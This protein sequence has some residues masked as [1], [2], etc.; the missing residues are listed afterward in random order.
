MDS[1][2]QQS[3]PL[4]IELPPLPSSDPD[5]DIEPDWDLGRIAKTYR[6]QVYELLM[7]QQAESQG[8]RSVVEVH[9]T[10]I[11]QLVRY[12]FTAATRLYTRRYTSLSQRCSVF[13][14]GG[15]GRGEL[16][17]HSDIDLLFLYHWKITPYAETVWETLYYSLMDAGWTVGHAV[18]NI[19]EC[20][21]QAGR[22]FEIKTSLL[23]SRYL[24]GEESLAQEFQ[25]AMQ[26]D[27]VEKRAEQFFQAKAEESRVR[28]QRHGDSLYLLEPNLKEGCG[29]LRDL[30]TAWWLA[31]VKFKLSNWRELIVK[32]VVSEPT[33]VA[34]EAAQDFLW[35]VRNG[36]HLLERTEQDTLTFEHQDQLAPACGFA[37]ATQFM[38]TY[39]QHVT[40]I[41]DF[42]RFMFER[43]AVPSRLFNF[44][45]RPR[46]RDIREGIR[47][48]DQ[49]LHVTKP[50]MLTQ[51]PLNLVSLFHD[52]QRHGVACSRETKQAIRQALTSLPPDTAS[53]PAVR[54]AFL[55]ILSWKQRVAPTLHA[56]HEV[57]LLEWLLPEF[58]HLRWRT[59]RDLYHIYAIDE[60]TL[61]GVAEL[62]RLRDGAY[63][64]SL[65]LLTQ[66]MREIDRVD[67]LF[68]SMLFHDVGKGFGV[69]HAGRSAEMVEAAAGRWQLPP[70]EAHEWQVL[71][72]QHLFMSHIAQ[73]RDLSDDAQ[74]A[75]F[76]RTVENPGCLKRLYLLTFADMKAVGPKVWNSWKGGLLN[77]LY[78]RTLERLETGALLEEEQGARLQRRKDRIRQRLVAQAAAEPLSRFLTAMPDSYFLTTPEEAVPE[79]FQLMNRFVQAEADA[80]ASPYRVSLRHSPEQ[81]YSEFTLVTRDRPGLFSMLAGVLA[82]SGLSISGARA[83]TSR[84]R[85]TSRQGIAL[86]VFRLSHLDRQ[87]LLL[88]EETWTR[89]YTRLN[90]VLDGERRV[91]DLLQAAR[92]PAF[93]QR[94]RPRLRTEITIDNTTSPTYTLVDVT[95]LDRIGL[96]FEVTHA[97]FQLGLVIHLAKITTN[98][99]QVLDVFYVTD[100]TGAKVGNPDQVMA[101][102]QGRL[103]SHEEAA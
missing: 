30:H 85:G 51:E 97:L 3:A 76:A 64:E 71:V 16:S 41:H 53:R 11:D 81:E 36:L 52:T 77:E 55:A 62:E 46:G 80:Q 32:G 56:M 4:L 60:H 74:I 86:D 93:L 91:E 57:G 21:R 96:L 19:R 49:T 43:C 101:E 17:P 58:G 2:Q 26:R 70:D 33:L 39:Y 13:A 54:D 98:V 75:D 1:A 50:E 73:R 65:P 20:L 48:V 24:C 5:V 7:Q 59:Q 90:A 8:G 102:L 84:V 14:L 100:V 6:A 40:T 28:H 99:D 83:F 94:A 88:S 103:R 37:D 78:L 72:R 89:F 31:K 34:V 67:L 47:I 87:D 9:T 66:V 95:A 69:E 38:R 92:P 18:R 22:D 29:G 35:R 25:T 82:V 45:G 42:T 79:H 44:L 27:L 68:L 23:D 63:K 12:V 61:H 15:Y 10:L